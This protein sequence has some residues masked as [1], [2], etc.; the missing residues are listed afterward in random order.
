MA[1]SYD[2][3]IDDIKEL[4]DKE[5][6]DKR[7]LEQILRASEN[8][9]VISNFE[10][11]YVDRLSE[12]YLNKKSTAEEKPK[13]PDVNLIQPTVQE[14]KPI[15]TET[16]PPQIKKPKNQPVFIGIGIAALAVIVIAAVGFSGM[17]SVSTPSEIDDTPPPNPTT[18]GGVISIQT[19]LSSYSKGDIISISGK[20]DP[21]LG[22]MISLSIEN[23]NGQLAWSENINVKSDGRFSTL[24]IAGGDEWS[25]SGTFTLTANHGNESE[26]LT[27]SFTN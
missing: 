6:G 23:Q 2:S 12:K 22:D 16:K 7:I 10:R 18:V 11:N 21:S 17:G 20:T 13:T 15:I 3:L 27:F 1:N 9:E 8:H 26:T 14:E 5:K 24:L 4:L 25:S 19:D